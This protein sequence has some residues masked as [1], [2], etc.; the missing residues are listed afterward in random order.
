MPSGVCF[1]GDGDVKRNAGA[2]IST[3]QYIPQLDKEQNVRHNLKQRVVYLA[4][5][6][7]LTG[8]NLCTKRVISQE[9]V[10]ALLACE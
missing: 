2:A 10:S 6:W 5:S 4:L 7:D 9:K 8:R 1:E 3:T